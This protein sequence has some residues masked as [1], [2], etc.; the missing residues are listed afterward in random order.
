MSHMRLRAQVPRR[1]ISPRRG[2]DAQRGFS[3]ML[4]L[5]MIAL[6]AGA[7]AVTLLSS[8]GAKLRSDR[9]TENALAKAKDALIAYAVTDPNRPGE[10]PCPDL[11]TN[12]GGNIP[13]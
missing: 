3:M 6:A 10:L 4:V 1:M 11:I 5:V 13:N 8:F 9:V 12:I 2:F 7:L